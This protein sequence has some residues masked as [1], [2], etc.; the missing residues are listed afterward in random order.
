MRTQKDLILL[1]GEHND[2]DDDELAWQMVRASDAK[3]ISTRPNQMAALPSRAQSMGNL[4]NSGQGAKSL[5]VCPTNPNPTQ[6]P[7]DGGLAFQSTVD[8]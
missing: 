4:L 7:R 6:N 1:N 5:C 8:G 2:D 3:P